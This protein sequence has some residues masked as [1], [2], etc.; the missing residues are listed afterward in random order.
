MQKFRF[1]SLLL[2]FC[3]L[4]SLLSPGAL[5]LEPPEL[6]AQAVLLVDLESG[7]TLYEKN[8]DAPRSPASLTKVMTILLTLEA[9]ERGDVSLDD[10]VTA[11]AD[12][13]SGMRD[14]S[15]SVGIR[16]GEELTVRD[17][18]YCAA[19]ASGNDACNVL[20]V[21]LAGSIPAFVER[22]NQ[23]A[24]EL[25][26]EQTRFVDPHGLSYDDLTSARD[27]YRIT[28]EA[29]RHPAFMELCDTRAYT[30]PASNKSGERQLK[31]S[32]AL[33][34][35]D[36]VYGAGYLYEGAHGVKTGYT[37]A[38]GYCLISTA[39]REGMRLMA[40]VLGCDGPYLSNTET[41]YSFVDSARLY[42]WAFSGFSIRC[43]LSEYDLVGSAPVADGREEQV[44]LRPLHSVFAP[45]PRDADPAG[46]TLSLRLYN[47]P[48]TAPLRAG[49]VLGQVQVLYEGQVLV[50]EEL[51]AAAPVPLRF[52]PGL[53]RTLKDYT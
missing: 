19:V 1:F 23:K 30:V 13:R 18:L 9:V 21:Y 4:F 24:G 25:G 14:D 12:C 29:M 5:A 35:P 41:R 27:L 10:T 3:L 53:A 37:R 50:T 33:I 36:G 32:N 17:L 20:A 6:T 46:L 48:L 15:S 47:E 40:I 52:W 28:R 31:S 11:G 49:Q 44:G 8:A 45:L 39:E 22:M 51:A 43:L 7:V 2:P 38:A 26:C 42:D 16:P 34:A